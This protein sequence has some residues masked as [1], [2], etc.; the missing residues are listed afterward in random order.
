MQCDRLFSALD[1]IGNIVFEP[2]FETLLAFRDTVGWVDRTGGVGLDVE[3]IQ[4]HH[5]RKVTSQVI[6]DLA[7]IVHAVGGDFRGWGWSGAPAV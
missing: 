6:R 2:S 4:L 1:R 5:T 3:R 7:C